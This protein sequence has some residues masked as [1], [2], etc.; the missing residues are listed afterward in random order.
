M[1]QRRASEVEVGRPEIPESY[2][3]PRSGEGMLSWGHV[4]ERMSVARNYWLATVRPDGRPHSV[5]VWGVWVEDR[6]HFGGGRSTQKAR[7][8]AGNRNV[9]AHSEGGEDVVILEGVAEE[10]TD[11]PLQERIDDAYEAKYGVRHGTPVWALQPRVVH[12]WTR[13]PADATRWVFR[14]K[15]GG[16]GNERE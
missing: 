7:N 13:F 10:V 9:V 11:P 1:E 8:L 16:D 6:L 15:L 4:G 12:A 5:P 14:R 3:V 2:G